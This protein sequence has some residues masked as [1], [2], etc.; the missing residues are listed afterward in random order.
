MSGIPGQNE[1]VG[2]SDWTNEQQ[3]QQGETTANGQGAETDGKDEDGDNNSHKPVATD[4]NHMMHC[5]MLD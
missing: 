4:T 5:R 1:G 3:R 2:D